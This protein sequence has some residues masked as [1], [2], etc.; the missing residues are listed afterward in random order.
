MPKELDF[1]FSDISGKTVT[2]EKKVPEKTKE[3]SNKT[4]IMLSIPI[5]DS[6]SYYTKDLG[7]CTDEEFFLWVKKIT[8]LEIN[9]EKCKSITS[10]INIFKDIING[11]QPIFTSNK[12]N[13]I[14]IH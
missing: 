12:N 10:R 7:E 1:D 8:H 3:N 2:T 14:E 5:K 11:Y 9:I 6:Q 13:K 4:D